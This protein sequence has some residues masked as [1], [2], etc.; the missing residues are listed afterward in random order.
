MHN[1][2]VPASSVYGW[3]SV[4][5]SWK[6]V[7]VGRVVG[8]DVGVWNPSARVFGGG[9]DDDPGGGAADGSLPTY[10][11]TQAGTWVG[12][13]YCRYFE[14]DGGD[15]ESGAEAAPV[16]GICSHAR[17]HVQQHLRL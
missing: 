12:V 3:D 14:A 15:L 13:G 1:V 9:S 2:W 16:H 10:P 6:E 11:G 8:G 4:E 5:R 17:T 7:V